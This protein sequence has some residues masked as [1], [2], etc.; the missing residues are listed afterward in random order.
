[1][2]QGVVEGVLGQ[3]PGTAGGAVEYGL[4]DTGLGVASGSKW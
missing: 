2:L 4:K 3:Q 1:M